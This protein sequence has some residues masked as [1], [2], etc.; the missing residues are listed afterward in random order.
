MAGVL[1]CSSTSM[2]LFLARARPQV[3]VKLFLVKRRA[4]RPL[5]AKKVQWLFLD[6]SLCTKFGAKSTFL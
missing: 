4:K 2:R 5:F 3:V 1:F 6:S